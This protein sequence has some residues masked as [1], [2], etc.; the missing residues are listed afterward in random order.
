MLRVKSATRGPAAVCEG[1]TPLEDEDVGE[2]SPQAARAIPADVSTT[3]RPTRL[4][5]LMAEC[6]EAK[7][8]N[9]VLC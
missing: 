3:A 4:L 8:N 1:P 7:L 6:R 9:A 2:A 5:I